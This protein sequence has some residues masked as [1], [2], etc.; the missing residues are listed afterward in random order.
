MD[1][2]FVRSIISKVSESNGDV[3]SINKIIKKAAEVTLEIG[4]NDKLMRILV[5]LEKPISDSPLTV[6][7]SSIFAEA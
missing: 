7:S 2:E 4:A 6:S 1:E 3:H 5:E